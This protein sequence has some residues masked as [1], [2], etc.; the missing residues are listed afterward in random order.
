MGAWGVEPFQND[1]AL[2]WLADISKK[3]EKTL[4]SALKPMVK[5]PFRIGVSTQGAFLR[6]V[7]K[8]VA[9]YKLTGRDQHEAFA[10][11]VL[12]RSL[13]V[14]HQHRLGPDYKTSLID[15]AEKVLDQLLEDEGFIGTW[16]LPFKYVAAIKAER[17]KIHALVLK[18][19][20][21]EEAATAKLERQIKRMTK[22]QRVVV[23]LQAKKRIVMFG[24]SYRLAFERVTGTKLAP[25]PA[26][27]WGS[28]KR[29]PRRKGRLAMRAKPRKK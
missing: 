14:L 28:T 18:Y 24:E 1:S 25:T 29:R 22:Q 13:P 15:L 16:R 9:E 27:S 10:A 17:R 21:V 4:K 20:G 5:R 11:V 19:R 3:I 12:V 26:F 7:R 8:T 6:R 23:V 2:D